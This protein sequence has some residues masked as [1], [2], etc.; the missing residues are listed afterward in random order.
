LKDFWFVFDSVLVAMMVLETWVA[1]VIFAIIGVS[2]GSLLGD[3]TMLRLLRLARLARAARLAKAVAAFPELMVLIKGIAAATRS[4]L[5]AFLVLVLVVYVG[6]LGF[7]QIS[8]ETALEDPYFSSVLH[9]CSTLMLAI[10]TP[11]LLGTLQEMDD[12]S[13]PYA[14]MIYCFVVM[15]TFVILNMLLGVLVQVVSMVWTVEKEKAELIIL[16]DHMLRVMVL[17]GN[18]NPE[19]IAREEFVQILQRPDSIRALTAA[20]VDAV[21]LIDHTDFLF[22]EKTALSFSDFL[23]SLLQLRGSN[24][25]TVKDIV[26]MRIM[27]DTS[28][29]RVEERLARRISQAQPVIPEAKQQ[30]RALT[31]KGNYGSNDLIPAVV[32]TEGLAPSAFSAIRAAPGTNAN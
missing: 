14:V 13:L 25:A 4:V 32:G 16:K 1:P 23:E 2:D 3:A 18:Q 31:C 8:K 12:D 11:D 30:R 9:G 7:R 5:F 10:T 24:P 17:V 19:E 22:Q 15:S 28:F 20:G 6:G 21:S 27:V 29:K 26:D